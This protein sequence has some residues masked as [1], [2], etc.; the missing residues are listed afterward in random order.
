M[1]WQRMKKSSKAALRPS[2]KEPRPMNKAKMAQPLNKLNK[3]LKE[4]LSDMLDSGTS[5]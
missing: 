4:L 2:K 5:T 3:F 1:I